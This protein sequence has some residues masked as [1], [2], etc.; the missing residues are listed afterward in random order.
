[1]TRLALRLAVL[2]LGI[3][4][5][6][7]SPASGRTR[8]H[9][10]PHSKAAAAPVIA[11]PTSPQPARYVPG[12]APPDALRY[13]LRLAPEWWGATACGGEIA[14]IVADPSTF[15]DAGQDIGYA[16]WTGIEGQGA[17]Y[18]ACSIW[19][20]SRFFASDAQRYLNWGSFCQTALHEYG[21]LLGLGHVADDPTNVMYPTGSQANVPPVCERDPR[22]RVA[23]PGPSLGHR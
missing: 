3:A 18:V 23:D 6:G 21:H 16:Q 8:A 10:H 5:M 15:P 19:F 9:G 2:C 14:V 13:M 1:M 17:T 7:P 22:G 4:L 12:L 20:S 11:R